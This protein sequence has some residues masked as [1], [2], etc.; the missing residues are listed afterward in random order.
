[1]FKNAKPFFKLPN[2][3][4]GT[5]EI[6]SKTISSQMIGK[7][8]SKNGEFLENGTKFVAAENFSQTYSAQNLK[9]VR[10]SIRSESVEFC[11]ATFCEKRCVIENL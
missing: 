4:P 5:F 1:M 3:W 6:N 2:F 11:R 9:V 8:F 7:T 10:K